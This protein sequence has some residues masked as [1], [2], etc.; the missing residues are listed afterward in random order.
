MTSEWQVWHDYVYVHYEQAMLITFLMYASWMFTF[1]HMFEAVFA[2]KNKRQAKFMLIENALDFAIMILGMF[3]ITIVYKVYRWE[4]FISQPSPEQL[5]S[6][7]WD[8]FNSFIDYLDDHLLLLFIDVAYLIKGSIGLRL[9]PVFGP[10]TQVMFILVKEILIFGLFFFIQQ[11]IYAV[12]GN[13]LFHDYESYS[14]LSASML[15]VFKASVGV[16]Y[17]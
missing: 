10:P 16:F 17:N 2:G 4:T 14:T 12:L 1:Q 15:T 8:N 13:L 9:F 7:Y 6:K 11:F 5:T 3:Y